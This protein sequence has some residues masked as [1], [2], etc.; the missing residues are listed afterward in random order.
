VNFSVQGGRGAGKS[1]SRFHDARAREMQEATRSSGRGGDRV[2]GAGHSKYIKN[3][4]SIPTYGAG[5]NSQFVIQN[6]VVS[7]NMTQPGRYI[8]N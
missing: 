2:A 3:V 4:M 7:V 1:A 8:D 6:S 5:E